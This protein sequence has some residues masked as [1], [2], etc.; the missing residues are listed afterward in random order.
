MI[1]DMSFEISRLILDSQTSL[2]MMFLDFYETEEQSKED[3]DDIDYDQ[4]FLTRKFKVITC[5]NNSNNMN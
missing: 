2:L 1:P 3:D 4:V 5:Q